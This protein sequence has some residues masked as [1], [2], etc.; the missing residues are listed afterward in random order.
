MKSKKI[1]GIILTVGGIVLLALSLLSDVIGIG[2]QTAFGW[3]QMVGT[4]VGA[5]AIVVGIVI[6]L[7]KK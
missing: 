2:N 3:R 6:F 7:I 5:I 1:L 4:A